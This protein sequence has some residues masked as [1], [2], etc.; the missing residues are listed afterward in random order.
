[1]DAILLV[2]HHQTALQL[3]E[4][5]GLRHTLTYIDFLLVV[6]ECPKGRNYR[7]KK[8][9]IPSQEAHDDDI[10]PF[11]EVGITLKMSC[12]TTLQTYSLKMKYYTIAI[13]Q[14]NK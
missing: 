2:I 6:H 7:E 12:D 14:R 11:V 13:M 5:A 4:L 9:E 8:L 10:L 3:P 1:V